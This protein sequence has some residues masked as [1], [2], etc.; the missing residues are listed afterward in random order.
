MPN[1]KDIPWTWIL[2]GGAIL[3]VG[4]FAFRRGGGSTEQKALGG[5]G[6]LVDIFVPEDVSDVAPE[7]APPPGPPSGIPPEVETYGRELA[8]A[9][10][11]NRFRIEFIQFGKLH[12]GEWRI[13]YVINVYDAEDSGI[14]SLPELWEG[15]WNP[16]LIIAEGHFDSDEYDAARNYYDTNLGLLMEAAE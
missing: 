3:A 8:A 6:E 14:E 10:I 5:D 2:G 15:Y 12:K 16:D 13:S 7:D 1:G 9:E 4:L 11:A